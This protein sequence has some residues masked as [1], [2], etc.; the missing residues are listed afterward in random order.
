KQAMHRG[1][2]PV[3]RVIGEAEQRLLLF[4]SAWE[5]LDRDNPSDNWAATAGEADIV[6]LLERRIQANANEGAEKRQIETDIRSRLKGLRDRYGVGGFRALE[7][8]D[9]EKAVNRYFEK[10]KELGAIDYDSLRGRFLQCLQH[11]K[12]LADE[13]GSQ[14]SA[15]LVDESQD[16]SRRQAEILLMLCGERSNMWV[17][18][19]PCQQ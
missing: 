17:I 3:G 11:H 19:D 12:K 9:L 2:M 13:F 10:L 16:T 5:V 6:G 7:W 18:G 15:M 4:Q 14:F 8:G 1:L